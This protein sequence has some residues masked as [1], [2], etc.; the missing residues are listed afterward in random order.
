MGLHEWLVYHSLRSPLGLHAWPYHAGVLPISEDRA[1]FCFFVFFFLEKI[2]SGYTQ[3]FGL[4][5]PFVPGQRGFTLI[6]TLDF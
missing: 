2:H 6:S 4:M 3:A 5:V 1:V